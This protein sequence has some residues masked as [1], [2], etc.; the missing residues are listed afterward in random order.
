[1]NKM[2]LRHH[3]LES[4]SWSASRGKKKRYQQNVSAL[5]SMPP[6]SQRRKGSAINCSPQACRPPGKHLS[7]VMFLKWWEILTQSLGAGSLEKSEKLTTLV[8]DLLLKLIRFCMASLK[9]AQR[10]NHRVDYLLEKPQA[11]GLVDFC[12]NKSGTW[13]GTLICPGHRGPCWS[14]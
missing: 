12:I 11:T 8:A 10:E 13:A 5:A 3:Q 7:E 14:F 6:P 1:M 2:C 9:V 4:V